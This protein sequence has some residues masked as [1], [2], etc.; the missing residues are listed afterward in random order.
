MQKISN[1]TK[2]TINTQTI[3]LL[4]YPPSAHTT[5]NDFEGCEFNFNI[6]GFPSYVKQ[7]WH[8]LSKFLALYHKS[9][10]GLITYSSANTPVSPTSTKAVNGYDYL[11]FCI[12]INEDLMKQLTLIF[13]MSMILAACSPEEAQPSVEI[14]QGD[15]IYENNFDDPTSWETFGLIDTQFGITDGKYVAISAGGGYIPV[16]NGISHNNV[17]IEATAEQFAGSSE[18]IYGIICRSHPTVTSLGYY[19]LINSS[20]SYGIRIGETNRIRVFVPWTEHPAINQ[21]IA[22]NTLRA[23]C[24]DDYFAFYINDQFVAEARHDW[25]TDGNMS[26][27]VSSPSGVEIAVKFD[28]VR[29]WSAS[30]VENA[31]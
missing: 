19:F 11:R 28:D 25:L 24:V 9:G 1:F 14:I 26:L 8:T 31:E 6:W 22:T 7:N 21:E 5:F 16:S 3:G 27:V 20:G 30:I 23:V 15:L 13:I 17:I 4:A 18:T 2:L 29:I 10:Q 12:A